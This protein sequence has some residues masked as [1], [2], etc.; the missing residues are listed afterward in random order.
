M[1]L[2]KRKYFGINSILYVFEDMKLITKNRSAFYD[3]SIEKQ[4]D[5]GIVLQW[6]E[7]KSI[8]SKQVNIKDAFIKLDNREFWII[9]MDVP[10]YSKTSYNLAPWYNS[11]ARRKLLFNKKELARISASLDVSGNILLPLEVFV[12]KNWRIKI[13]VWI[14]KL[15]RKIEKRQILKEKDIKRQM[16]RDIKNLKI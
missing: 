9:W 7:V 10:L 6:H 15:M 2:Q 1:D 16:D 3:Y 12:T 4:Y 11:K 8:K 13:K 5:A 14:A